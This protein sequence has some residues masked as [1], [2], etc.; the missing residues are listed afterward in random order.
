MWLPRVMAA[1]RPAQSVAAAPAKAVPAA[2]NLGLTSFDREGQ[3]QI[4]WDRASAAVRDAAY[5]V[6]EI[7]EDGTVPKAI[8]LDAA[9]LQTGSFAYQRT[10][11][12]VDLKLVIHQKQGPDL[13]ESFSF[14][15]KPPAANAN[16]AEALKQREAEAIKQRD[17]MAK[18][19]AK[20][21]ADLTSQAAKT[22]KL[23][24]DMQS[25][26]EEMRQQQ[27]RRLANQVPDK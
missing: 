15:G 18:Q 21:K 1:I 14:L 27:R 11:A 2:P 19:T 13:R 5:G 25:M 22:K 17:E 7:S 23:E 16:D 24:Q 3:L 26:R 20:M 10:T 4:N 12:K 6:L 9:S 8:Q